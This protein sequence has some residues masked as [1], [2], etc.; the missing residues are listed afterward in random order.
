MT[1]YDPR[2]RN[3][4]TSRR[5]LN[6]RDDEWI[7]DLLGRLQICR[8]STLWQG[9]DGE[10]FPFINPTSFVYRPE[11]HD[12]I[13]HSNLAG[14]LRAN[15]EN[16]Q[17]TTFEASEMG[18]FLPSNDPLEFSVQY[19][20]VVAFGLSRLL[21]GEEARRALYRLCAHIFPDIR[22]GTEMQPISDEQL[23]RTSVYSL[24]IERWSGKE[25]WADQADQTLD[26]PALPEHLLKPPA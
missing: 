15:T 25:N 14:R 3:P 4:A 16:S 7:R 18:R 2:A 8:I 12:L 5:P 9:E 22:P 17:R 13:Y 1:Y 24:S 10:A 23:S 20:S 11:T 19:R 21:E 26:W 6:R